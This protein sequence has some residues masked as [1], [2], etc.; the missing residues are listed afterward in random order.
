MSSATDSTRLG[1]GQARRGWTRRRWAL[2]LATGAGVTG[3]TVGGWALW[4][5]R[6]FADLPP[7][8]RKMAWSLSA[9]ADRMALAIDDEIV[10]A[11]LDDRVRFEGEIEDSTRGATWVD[12]ESLVLSTDAFDPASGDEVTRYVSYYDP[13]KNPCYNPLRQ[14]A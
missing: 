3:A 8:A 9:R 13:H 12:F 5:W 11:F 6:R 4:R 10:R 2:A 14:P 1:R 7:G